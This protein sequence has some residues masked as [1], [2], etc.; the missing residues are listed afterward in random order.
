MMRDR[1]GESGFALMA[2]IWFIALL[3][4]VSVV[5]AGWMQRSLGL[6]QRLQER[7]AAHDATIGA[8]SEVAFRMVTGFF[9]ARGLELPQG[10]ERTGAMA[11]DNPFG[12][13]FAR[14]TRYLG[15]DDRPY[16]LGSVVVRLQDESGLY[17]LNYPEPALLGNLLRS[18]GIAYNDRDVLFERL[19]DYMDKSEFSRLNGATAADYLSAGRPPPRG[20]PLLTP[21]EASRVLSWDSYPTLW[22][23][24]DALPD[25]TGISDRVQ[26]NPN[27]APAAIL[28][29]LPGMDE[30]AAER[31]IK[32]RAHYIMG[33]II[34]LDRAAGVGIP[35][36]P[37][38]LLFFPSGNLQVT[39]LSADDPL[40]H[41]LALRLTAIGQAPYRVDYAVN[42]PADDDAAKLARAGD[43]PALLEPNQPDSPRQ[44]D[45]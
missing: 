3:G 22:R 43:L 6:A 14:E 7:L 25:L 9:S 13:A 26:L 40:V 4:L 33:S 19:L 37:M 29:S 41:R 17:T 8:E 36:D 38:E 32:Y 5:I 34:D 12:Y 11:P 20:A 23:G 42:L 1:E 18:Y 15:L 16:K 27:T 31:V 39:I 24:S 21:W 30:D 2:A 28:R 45:Q 35:V 44:V 10:N